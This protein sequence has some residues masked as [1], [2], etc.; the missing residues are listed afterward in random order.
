M[1]NGYEISIATP[2]CFEVKE[3]KDDE[4]LIYC[5]LKA[6]HDLSNS[7]KSFI[8]QDI[9]K[10]RI[11]TMKDRPIMANIVDVED[12]NG[13]MVNDF[14]GHS[15]YYDEE[16]N[17]TVYVEIPVGHVINPGNIRVEYDE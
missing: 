6:F 13:N 14:S 10:K 4:G 17:K 12:E 1:H 7:N 8:E 5:D 15:N 9:F 2:G 11:K 16:K 3:Y